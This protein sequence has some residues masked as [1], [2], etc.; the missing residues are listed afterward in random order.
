MILKQAG[1]SS[2]RFLSQFWKLMIHLGAVSV[3]DWLR[4]SPPRY[5]AEHVSVAGI[6]GDQSLSLL[7][8]HGESV[9]P[10]HDRSR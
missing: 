3:G 5:G 1:Y 6:L 2:A 8:C 10:E 4:S 7:G 9:S